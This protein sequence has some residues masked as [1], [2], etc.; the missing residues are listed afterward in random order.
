MVKS[1]GNEMAK[2][3][4]LLELVIC[5]TVLAVA[6]IGLLTSVVESAY[7]Q[8]ANQETVLALNQ[9]RARLEQVKETP[10]SE[11]L[12]G[13]STFDCV[14]GSMSLNRINADVPVGTL[15]IG[16][17]DASGV[18]QVTV[19]VVWKSARGRAKTVRLGTYLTKH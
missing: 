7:L 12:P 2:G 9:A 8:K 11:V 14:Q 5:M 19:A 13:N 15:T 4:T 3:F 18:K 6:V 1:A 17:E 10:Y 16:A